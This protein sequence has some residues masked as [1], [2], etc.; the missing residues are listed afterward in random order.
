MTGLR[1]L[2]F[3]AIRV[4]P[5]NETYALCKYMNMRID[6]YSYSSYQSTRVYVHVYVCCTCVYV[7]MYECRHACMHA[8]MY[9]CMYV[10]MY[11][12]MYVSMYVYV[13]RRV[14]QNIHI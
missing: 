13:H 11:A 2:Y 6:E 14:S 3:E 4:A 12:C 5:E 8:C 1:Y 9:V 7:C 10:C